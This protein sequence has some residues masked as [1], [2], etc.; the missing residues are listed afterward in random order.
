MKNYIKAALATFLILLPTGAFFMLCYLYPVLLLY[1]LKISSVII[2]LGIVL[3][4][5]I[6]AYSRIKEGDED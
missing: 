1:L 4:I 3:L 5:Y 6:A 2:I